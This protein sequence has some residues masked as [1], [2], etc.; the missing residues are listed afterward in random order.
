MTRQADCL[1]DALTSAGFAPVNDMTA[2][3]ASSVAAGAAGTEK[4]AAV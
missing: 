1:P 3:E 4:Q 2:L